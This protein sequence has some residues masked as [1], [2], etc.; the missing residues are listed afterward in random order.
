MVSFP[1]NDDTDAS[2]SFAAFL[3]PVIYAIALDS[4]HVL[5]N[6]HREVSSVFRMTASPPSPST[7]RA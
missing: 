6:R 2:V 4:S 5:Q 7:I 3:L 1:K